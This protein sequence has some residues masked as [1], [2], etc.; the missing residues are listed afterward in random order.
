MLGG[1][2]LDNLSTSF[3]LPMIDCAVYIEEIRRGKR[4]KRIVLHIVER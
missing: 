2:I 4:K 3:S 1:H